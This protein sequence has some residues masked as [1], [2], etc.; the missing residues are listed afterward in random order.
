MKRNFFTD[1]QFAKLTWLWILAGALMVLIT[2]ANLTGW[3]LMST[4]DHSKW[5]SSGPGYHK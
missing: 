2:Y 1:P 4:S 3:R 5:E